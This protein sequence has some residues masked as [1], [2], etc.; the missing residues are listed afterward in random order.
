MKKTVSVIGSA[1]CSKREYNIALEVGRGIA[2][3]N[4]VVV[5]GGLGGV[6]E[7]CARGAKEAGG[8]TVGL[9]PGTNKGAANPYI[10]IAISTGLY[11]ARNIIIASGSDAVIAIGGALGTLSELSLAMKRKKPVI[12]IDTW[13]LDSGYCKEINIFHVS[14]VNQALDKTFEF[15]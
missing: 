11:E 6:M 15:I 4:A 1:D 14:S 5:C 3:R 8:I 7:A 10:D 9:L 2:K 12:G 13:Q